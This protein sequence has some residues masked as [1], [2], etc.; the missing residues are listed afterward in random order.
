[1]ERVDDAADRLD[2]LRL[3]MARDLFGDGPAEI[4][5]VRDAATAPRGPLALVAKCRVERGPVHAL[6]GLLQA[7]Q[8]PLTCCFGLREH[9]LD[10]E[11]E[12]AIERADGSPMGG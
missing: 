10:A 12:I 9:L 7:F 5:R 8:P 1:D 4:L 3:P 6:G 2:D 11:L